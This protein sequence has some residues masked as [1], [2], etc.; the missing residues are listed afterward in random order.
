MTATAGE[1]ELRV[2]VGMA[3]VYIQWQE[4]GVDEGEVLQAL[5]GVCRTFLVSYYVS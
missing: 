1:G 3:R 2:T 4:W 5:E